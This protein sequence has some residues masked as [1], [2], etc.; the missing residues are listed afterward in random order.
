MG[1]AKSVITYR[2][3]VEGKQEK[4]YFEHLRNLINE[5]SNFKRRVN[6]KFKDS[7]GGSPS[8]IVN[9]AKIYSSMENTIVAV[10]DHDFKK[11]DFKEALKR[12]N[13]YKIFPAFSIE[14]FNLFL[15]LHKEQY[16]KQIIPE[17][18]YE[19]DLRRVFHLEKD[20]DVKSEETIQK[21]LSQITLDD[22]KNALR[23]AAIINQRSKENNKSIMKDIYEQ[24]FLN[25]NNFVERV[26][27]E[28]NN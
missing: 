8:D 2:G 12:C 13:K 1:A 9:T 20:C 4:L 15:I 27:N 22:V 26:F 14:N 18:N 24:P 25:I 7:N 5:S 17:D 19:K 16:Y 21:I 10:F 11:V 28:L 3:A 23:N 6:F